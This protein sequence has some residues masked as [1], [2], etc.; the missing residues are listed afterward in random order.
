MHKLEL[1]HNSIKHQM[2]TV[3]MP[4]TNHA[5]LRQLPAMP[6]PCKGTSHTSE[7][8]GAGSDGLKCR[9]ADVCGFTSACVRSHPSD[10]RLAHN[11]SW[12][13]SRGRDWRTGPI[14]TSKALQ[15]RQQHAAR[16][17]PFQG[18]LLRAVLS[19]QK[20]WRATPAGPSGGPTAHSR[21][22]KGGLPVHKCCKA[23]R[24]NPPHRFASGLD[25]PRAVA[26]IKIHSSRGIEAHA[27][28]GSTPHAQSKMAHHP[29]QKT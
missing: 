10:P 1:K 3:V 21:A 12:H 13:P 22:A 24:L 14:Q 4:V 9:P 5:H 16:A 2:Q 7:W 6:P 15:S 11:G 26:T 27:A 29:M 8:V 17:N 28:C 18:F 23:C 20:C 19:G 25:N